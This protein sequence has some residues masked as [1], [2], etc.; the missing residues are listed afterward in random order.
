M[1]GPTP[2]WDKSGDPRDNTVDLPRIDAAGLTDFRSRPN[3][4]AGPAATGPG[5]VPGVPGIV[6]GTREILPGTPEPPVTGSSGPALTP[7]P[8]PRPDT[9]SFYLPGAPREPLPP[10][11]QG[12]G[13]YLRDLDP[14]PERLP[15]PAPVPRLPA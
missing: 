3:G 13:R 11:G 7:L 8:E 6:P 9:S 14:L 12:S 15:D 4:A 1:P 2:P 10:S 5:P